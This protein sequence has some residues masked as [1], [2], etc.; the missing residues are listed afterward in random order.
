[1]RRAARRLAEI[2]RGKAAV[3]PVLGRG[4]ELVCDRGFACGGK[5]AQLGR[6][7]FEPVGDDVYDDALALQSAAH[8][9]QR[10]V[11]RFAMETLEDLRPDDDIGGA[12]FVFERGEDHALTSGTG[13]MVPQ[14][15]K[16]S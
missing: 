2:A 6:A 8:R 4:G 1:M 9:Q 13:M 10:G 14:V 3:A 15:D 11:H 12:G 16:L 7:I 5:Y